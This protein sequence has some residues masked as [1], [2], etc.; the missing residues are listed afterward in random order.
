VETNDCKRWDAEKVGKSSNSEKKKLTVVAA[1]RDCEVSVTI[2][3]EDQMEWEIGRE[4]KNPAK[5][6]AARAENVG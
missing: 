1:A 6:E 2:G 5:K 4:G 3:L